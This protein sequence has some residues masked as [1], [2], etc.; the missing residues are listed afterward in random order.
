MI[1]TSAARN[2]AACFGHLKIGTEFATIACVSLSVAETIRSQIGG[3]AL[4]LMGAKDLVGDETSLQFR[5]ARSPK[6]A[7]SVVIKLEPTD[8]YTVTAYRVTRDYEVILVAQCEDIGAEQL[9]TALES[10]TGLYVSLH[11]RTG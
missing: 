5:V 10:V 3:E 4:L 11:R 2:Q 1:A 6:K 7:T 8:F 9:L